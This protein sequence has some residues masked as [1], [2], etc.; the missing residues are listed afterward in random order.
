MLRRSL[1]ILG[2]ALL[3]LAALV[4][5]PPLWY[6][7]FPDPAPELPPAGR[8]LAVSPDL[9]V[10]VLEKGVGSPV[11]LVH[12]HPACA[13]DWKLV[14]SELVQRG[15]RVF[16]YD[17]VGYGRSDR[18]EPGHVSVETNAEEL[19]GLL[20]ALELEEVTLAGWSYGG[21]VSLVAA[22]LDASRIARIALVG[23]VGP[24]IGERDDVPEIPSFLAEFMA[25]PVF[26]WVASIPPLAKRLGGALQ[27]AAFHPDPVPDPVPDWYRVQSAANF[28]RRNTRDAMRSEGRDLNGEANLD[29]TDIE[30][31]LLILHG[32][33]DQLSPY[34]VAVELHALAPN[35]QLRPISQAGHMLPVTHPELL[36]TAIH[37]FS[38]DAAR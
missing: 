36:A 7:L 27:E 3:A 23:S 17:R 24:G 10:N 21:G 28:A 18:R 15:H 32:A 25:G 13:Y 5:L 35:S 22:K 34:S 38:G 20:A 29:P 19:L 8:S 6:V 31:P 26:L 30:L 2:N 37:D 16:A 11:V 14:M 4:I 9:S 33:E 12:G 1:V